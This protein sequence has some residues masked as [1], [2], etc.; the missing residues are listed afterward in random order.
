MAKKGGPK[1]KVK[2]KVK[3][4]GKKLSALYEI[5]GESITRKNRTCPKCGP[6][7]FLAKHKNRIVCGK[8]QYVEFMGKK[9]E[10]TEEKSEE[11]K[12]EVKKE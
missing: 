6:G 1:G 9:E 5:S 3:K 7:M 8:C 11:V 4:E 10:V 12:E 2:E